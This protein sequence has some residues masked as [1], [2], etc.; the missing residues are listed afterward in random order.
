[1]PGRQKVDPDKIRKLA[2]QGVSAC[3]IAERIGCSRAVVYSTLKIRS[4][5]AV[6]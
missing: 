3:C 2:A 4:G 5:G 6:K 1:M